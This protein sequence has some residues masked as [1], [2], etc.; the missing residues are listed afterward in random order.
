M[1]RA[2]ASQEF[3]QVSTF[4]VAVSRGD[5]SSYRRRSDAGLVGL[6][7][8]RRTSRNASL[9]VI[10][11]VRVGVLRFMSLSLWIGVPFAI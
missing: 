4:A 11:T 6:R 3:S 10:D 2:P 9:S 8:W 7:R 1:R 5:E